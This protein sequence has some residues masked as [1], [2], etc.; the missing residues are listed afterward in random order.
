MQA[1][2]CARLHYFSDFKKLHVVQ[3][4]NPS[5]DFPTRQAYTFERMPKKPGVSSV[6]VGYYQLKPNSFGVMK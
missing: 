1:N 5:L 4:L 6:F 3:G 2:K